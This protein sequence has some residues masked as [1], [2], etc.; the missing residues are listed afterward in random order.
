MRAELFGGKMAV[1][2]PDEFEDVALFRPVPDNQEV[3]TN[4]KTDSSFIIELLEHAG[5][6]E[7]SKY[8]VPA[9][10]FLHDLAT[11]QAV[12]GA[13]T[14]ERAQQL[15]PVASYLQNLQVQCNDASMAQGVLSVTKHSESAANTVRVCV[16]NIRLPA[17]GT[18]MLLTVNQPLYISPGSSTAA[19]TGAGEAKLPESFANELMQKL[20]CSLTVADTSLFG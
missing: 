17:Y 9:V 3:F 5:A 12:D 2:V 7:V 4:A 11:V 8:P 6:L 10:F 19:A 20:L 18:D 16:A 13:C 1:D 14:L 15:H